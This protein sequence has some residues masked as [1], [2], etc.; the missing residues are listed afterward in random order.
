MEGEE[1]VEWRSGEMDGWCPFS[2]GAGFVTE[3]EFGGTFKDAVEDSVDVGGSVVTEV[4]S[5]KEG[6]SRRGCG[7][8]NKEGKTS[9]AGEEAKWSGRK[10]GE[11]SS[12]SMLMVGSK[13][14]VDV[15]MGEGDF[16]MEMGVVDIGP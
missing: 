15:Q 6:V 9:V 4:S 1:G 5:C 12:S 16:V 11:G 10:E 7:G 14:G 3:D 8:G 13:A 2:E